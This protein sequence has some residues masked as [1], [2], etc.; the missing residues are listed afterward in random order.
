MNFN[1]CLCV[2][3]EGPTVVAQELEHDPNVAH[4]THGIDC[5]AEV[6]EELKHAE[7]VNE[8]ENDVEDYQRSESDDNEIVAGDLLLERRVNQR[9]LDAEDG[10]VSEHSPDPGVQAFMEQQNGNDRRRQPSKQLKPGREVQS[11]EG[12]ADPDQNAD[13]NSIDDRLLA[14]EGV[15]GGFGKLRTSRD[16]ALSRI[17]RFVHQVEYQVQRHVAAAKHVKD[18][19]TVAQ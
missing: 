4:R 13:S 15:C 10:S 5:E 17:G 1:S 19:L 3:N 8:N 7:R 2:L 9:R 16:A 11:E 14:R 12:V 18:R 6:R